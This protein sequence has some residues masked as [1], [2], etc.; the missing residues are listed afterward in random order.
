MTGWMSR[1]RHR[2]SDAETGITLVEMVVTIFL[3][4][5]I[6]GTT[7]T[8]MVL[9][10]R[11]SRTSMLRTQNTQDASLILERIT[12]PLRMAIRPLADPSTAPFVT[13]GSPATGTGTDVT[14]YAAINT[15]VG[16]SAPTGPA[17]YR[18][19]LNTTTGDLVEQVT[20]VTVSGG[21]FSWPS[22]TT[23]TYTIGRG[24]TVPQKIFTYC[25]ENYDQTKEDIG[26]L[27]ATEASTVDSVALRL[28]VEKPSTPD[29]PATVLQ[30]RVNL[31]NHS[32]TFVPPTG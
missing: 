5:V 30:N 27:D 15:I 24:L 21:N 20:P 10:L 23:A 9:G 17:K 2:G 11:G 22:N 18:F 31:P 3:T 28:S 4:L 26:P 19:Y 16:S 29:V 25:D 7:G 32:A 12:K 8:T 14:F 6:L 13:G 1:V